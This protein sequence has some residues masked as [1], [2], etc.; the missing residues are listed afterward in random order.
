MHGLL[1]VPSGSHLQAD[2]PTR[3][4]LE[5]FLKEVQTL[6]K[7]HH[8]NIVQFYGACLE[9]GSMFFV[10]ELMKGGDLYTALRH[11]PETMK[12]ER[13]GRK[14]AL[15]VALGLN[16]LHAQVGGAKL[17]TTVYIMGV[18]ETSR[19]LVCFVKEIYSR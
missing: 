12:W 4:D 6:A 9:T 14:V 5:L 17:H 1:T 13:L 3:K 19:M 15:D 10:T 16:Y 7:L 11:H 18:H 2:S 8:R